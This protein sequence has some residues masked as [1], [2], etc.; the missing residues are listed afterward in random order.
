[1]L[2]HQL[3]AEGEGILASRMCKLIHKAFEID[4]VVI[5]VHAAPEA[6]N[7]VRIAHRMLDQDIRD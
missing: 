7:N 1:M 3:A 2:R 4:R 5:D 6:R